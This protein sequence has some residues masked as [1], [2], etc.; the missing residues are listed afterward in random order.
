ML[1]RVENLSR[2]EK[3]GFFLFNFGDSIDFLLFNLIVL[4]YDEN[5]DSKEDAIQL[6]KPCIIL[7]ESY[8]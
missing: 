7:L 8:K 6:K 2:H 4:C 1:A 3:E 5:Q